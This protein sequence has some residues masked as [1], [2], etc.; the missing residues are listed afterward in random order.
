LTPPSGGTGAALAGVVLAGGR[1]R[2]LGGGI[3]ALAGLD[4]K[5]LASHVIDRIRPQVR[6]LVISVEKANSEFSRF[7]LPCLDDPL[8]GKQGPLGGLLS[9]LK[10]MGPDSDWL[11]LV[12]CDAPFL[13]LD[14]GERLLA[15][16]IEQDAPGCIIRY[17]EELQPTF[18][19]WH[20]ALL[21][22]AEKA[23]L[24]EGLG[25][26]KQF[27]RGLELGTLDWETMPVSPFFNINTA[28][29]LMQAQQ[30][31]DRGGPGAQ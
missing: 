14:L 25:G 9:A 27:L 16:A 3:K 21:P 7:G 17:R 10:S 1:S 29:E 15:G 5:P 24:Q 22:A 28:E 31:L 12:P 19:L 23:V 11:L 8:P 6:S 13:P 2:R 30:I 18:S 26:F 4:G 20:R